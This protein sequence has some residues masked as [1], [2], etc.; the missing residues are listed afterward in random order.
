[1]KSACATINNID[2]V[3]Q[4]SKA[5][6]R[7]DGMSEEE[8]E[9]LVRNMIAGLPGA[10]ESFTIEQF[11]AALDGYKDITEVELRNNLIYFINE[12][13]AVAEEVGVQ[14]AIHPD[15]P[16]RSI[17]GLPRILSSADDVRKLFKAIP[18]KSNGLCLCTGSFGVSSENDLTSMLH[19]FGERLYFVHFRSTKRNEEGDFYEDNHLEGDVDMYEAMKSKPTLD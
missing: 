8:K 19:E 9:T 16:P 4:I 17:L 15:D 12:I 13:S 5:K 6:T 18:S 7:F 2:T 14:L 10:E 1:M 11:Q 3:D